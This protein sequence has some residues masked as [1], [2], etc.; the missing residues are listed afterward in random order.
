MHTEPSRD[1]IIDTVSKFL[2]AQSER[3]QI[4][5]K[6]GS[7]IACIEGQLYIYGIEKMWTVSLPC[8]LV[9]NPELLAH[10][11]QQPYLTA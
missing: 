2:D 10:V 4:C 5:P 6:C 9:C 7:N 8:C 11:S 1:Q 3:K